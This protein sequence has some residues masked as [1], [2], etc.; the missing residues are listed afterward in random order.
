MLKKYL[1]KVNLVSFGTRN[2]TFESLTL[3]ILFCLNLLGSGTWDQACAELSSVPS[4]PETLL[5]IW[6]HHYLALFLCQSRG[7]IYFWGAQKSHIL[8]WWKSSPGSHSSYD[9]RWPQA[10]L[11]GFKHR[12][13][14]E[15]SEVQPHQ[16]SP[17]SQNAASGVSNSV[18]RFQS[19]WELWRMDQNNLYPAKTVWENKTPSGPASVTALCNL[20]CSASI[21]AEFSPVFLAMLLSECYSSAC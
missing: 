15:I 11:R 13:V 21:I 17:A 16:Q 19:K 1:Q 12:T 7:T 6:R 14:S 2:K 3:A 5:T 8:I 4:I 10:A 20:L 18:L 9:K